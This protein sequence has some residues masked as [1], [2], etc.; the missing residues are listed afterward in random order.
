[1]ANRQRGSIAPLVHHFLP[2]RTRHWSSERISISLS[3]LVASDE[4]TSGSVIAKQD[5]ADP[6]NSGMRYSFCC[7]GVPYLARTSMFPVSGALQLKTSGANT[8][9]PITSHTCAYSRLERVPP[10]SPRKGLIESSIN[11]AVSFGI[12]RFHRPSALAFVF[13]SS[14]IGDTVHLLSDIAC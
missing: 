8:H 1:M 3:M 14:I 6:S 4:A 2:V 13:S 7:S 9:W 10:Y 12:K 5:R 11:S